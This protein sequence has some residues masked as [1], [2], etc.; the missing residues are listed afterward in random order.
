MLFT[1]PRT[2]DSVVSLNINGFNAQ[3]KWSILMLLLQKSG[4]HVIFLQETHF[5]ASQPQPLKN[6]TFPTSFYA[7][8]PSL[9]VKGVATLLHKNC[10][11]QVKAVHRDPEARYV[12]I[13]GTWKGVP[14]TMVHVYCIPI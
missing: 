2:Q 14:V 8:D 5:L 13:K 6:K 10:Q 9:K 3:G 7:S 12:F 4:A 1:R 11:F